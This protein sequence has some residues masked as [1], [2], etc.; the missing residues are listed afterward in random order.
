MKIFRRNQPITVR[1]SDIPLEVL[2]NEDIDNVKN[3]EFITLAK[4]KPISF[5]I[6]DLGN[7][8]SV[9]YEIEGGGEVIETMFIRKNEESFLKFLNEFDKSKLN[10][11]N[12]VI[13]KREVKN[14]GSTISITSVKS[15]ANSRL[16]SRQFNY[17]K[18]KSS[19]R[20]T[21]VNNKPKNFNSKL[22]IRSLKSISSEGSKSNI[23]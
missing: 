12:P 8:Q 9:K 14:R 6:V 18:V 5:N 22:S 16:R 13:N 15:R 10:K 3:I 20:L 21:I 23:K 19:S 1:E 4:P 11:N 2:F 17:N 7:H